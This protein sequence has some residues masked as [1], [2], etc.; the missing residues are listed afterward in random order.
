MKTKSCKGCGRAEWGYGSL[1]DE[2]GYCPDCALCHSAEKIK[3]LKA[4][5]EDA[6]MVI[7]HYDE[8]DQHYML[9]D[10]TVM[11]N[12]WAHKYLLKWGVK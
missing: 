7:R 11:G 2:D 4:Q 8:K 9:E 1:L 6:N 12:G 3:R 10:G 5:L